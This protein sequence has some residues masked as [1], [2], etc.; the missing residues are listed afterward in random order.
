VIVKLFLIVFVPLIALTL[1]VQAWRGCGRMRAEGRLGAL[2]GFVP[3][4]VLV[5]ENGSAGIALDRDSERFAVYRKA[6]GDVFPHILEMGNLLWFEVFD[7]GRLAASAERPGAG[8]KPFADPAWKEV[9]V[10]FGFRTGSGEKM[11]RLLLERVCMGE[12]SRKTERERA[13]N[14]ALAWAERLGPIMMDK[15]K[16]RSV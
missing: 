15:G 6:D 14:E 3:K 11:E 12:S 10:R 2:P 9:S 13:L 7:G 16:E 5:S 1:V 4:A 8:G